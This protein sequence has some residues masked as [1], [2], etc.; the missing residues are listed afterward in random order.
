M[1]SPSGSQYPSQYGA[2]APHPAWPNHSPYQAPP[3]AP[4]QPY[5]AAPPPGRAAVPPQAPP[6]M[7]PHAHPVAPPQ[8]YPV[9]PP[10]GGQ[11]A[12][13]GQPP[14]PQPQPPQQQPYGW[15]GAPSAPVVID[16]G[17]ADAKRFVIAS[18]VCGAIGLIA[19]CAGLAG[20]VNGG[21]GTVITMV[22]IG[23]VFLLI[24]AL[25][26]LMRK[27]A[28]RPRRLVIEQPGIRWDDPQ[29]QPWAVPWHE[30]AA[31]AISKHGALE[32]DHSMNA[33]VSGAISDRV[34]GE[35]VLVRL[36]MFPA[37]PGFH[38][39]HPEMAHLWAQDR[40]R[41][42][43]GRSPALI[44]QIDAAIRHF[45]PMRYQGIQETEGFMG[46]R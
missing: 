25:P 26:L 13:P 14:P 34:L 9:A 45:Q 3:A 31:V 46:L 4:A 17:K 6:A 8:A 38:Q 42:P 2:R 11:P 21:I 33:K 20:A 23:A 28:F 1:T 29:G 40:Y 37:D 22:V 12:W 5:P 36:D 16:V 7:P 10:Q 32:V 43:F 30:L 19:I 41:M 18:V 15:A 35:S 27:K 24:A 39:R 44:P